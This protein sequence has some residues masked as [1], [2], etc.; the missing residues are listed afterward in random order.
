MARKSL[1]SSLWTVALLAVPSASIGIPASA[2][3]AIV[4]VV[5]PP[6]FEITNSRVS[7]W[8]EPEQ[9]MWG[10][11]A[12]DGS[13]A[14]AESVVAVRLGDQDIR[15]SGSSQCSAHREQGRDAL[16]DYVRLKVVHTGL[17]FLEELV[18]TATLRPGTAYSVFALSARAEPDAP[19]ALRGLDILN[20]AGES[21]LQFGAERDR[22]MCFRDSGHQGGT[23]VVPY[24]DAEQATYSSP[25]TLMV[26]DGR[27]GQSLLLGWLSW[28]GSNPSVQLAGSKS[29]GITSVSAQCAYHADRL[30]QAASEPLL[31]SVEPDPL[32]ALEQYAQEVRRVNDP[33]IR[34][35]TVLGWLSWYCSRLTMT[36]EFVLDNARIIAGRF[37]AYGVDTMQADHGWEY[38][39]IVGH[40]VANDRFPHGMKWLGDELSR[41]DLKLGIWMAASCV[42]EFAPFYS[43]H[44]GALIRNADGTPKVFVERWHWAPHGRVFSLDPTDPDAQQHYRHSLQALMDAGSRYYKVDFIGRAGDTGALFH[45]P[46]RARGNPMLRY[47][48]QQ[49]RDEIGADSWLRYCSSPTNAYCG[50]VNIGGATMDIGNASGN[51]D[52]LQRYHQQLASCWYKHR[53]FWHNEPDALIVGEGGENEARLRCAWL[54]LSGGVVALGDDLTRIPPE[55]MAMIPKCLPPYNV[56]ARPLDLFEQSRARIWDL[57]VRTPWDAYHVVGLFN[58]DQ[59]EVSVP[60]PLARLGLDGVPVVAWEFW[61]QSPICPNGGDLNV[62]IP[63]C[64]CR[65]VAVREAKEHPQ[66]LAT[67]MHLT[68]GAVELSKVTWNANTRTLSGRALRAPGEKGTVFVHIPEGYEAI[69]DGSVRADGILAVPLEFTDREVAWSVPFSVSDSGNTL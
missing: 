69:E 33:P 51:W 68:M 1:S 32:A 37:R 7:V 17:P 5:D 22:W 36:E 42:S 28:A 12:R 8:Y 43:E 26:H 9:G 65:V 50:I 23:G 40:W 53:T 49:I 45:D 20:L 64:D 57:A 62:T 29:Q 25:A 58:L 13:V 59:Q 27:A 19:G 4:T 31:V 48:M 46:G 34:Q 52:H 38:R 6:K 60:I 61:T 55:R 39:D 11:A 15:T 2:A 21:S 24:F 41:L 63:G 66:A 56:A 67:D 47:E 16:G 54:A 35:D 44:P 14:L 18:W 3:D 10:M 30:K